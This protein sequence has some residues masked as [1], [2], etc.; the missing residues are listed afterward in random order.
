MLESF[1]N[2]CLRFHPVVDF[3]MRRALSDDVIEGHRVLKGT[4]IILNTGRMHH[5]EF[6]L[7]PDD[8]SLENFGRTVSRRESWFQVSGPSCC[9]TS[10]P[11]FWRR[12]VKDTLLLIVRHRLNAGRVEKCMCS[13]TVHTP[14]A[15]L[16]LTSR[17]PAVSSSSSGSSPLL[18]AVRIG[19]SRLRGEARGHGHDEIRPGDAPLPLLGLLPLWPDAGLPPTDQQPQPA[20]CRTSA[21]SPTSG[22][23]LPAAT[24]RP[25]ANTLSLNS[26]CTSFSLQVVQS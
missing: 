10:C 11:E 18:P 21:G 4:N 14:H 23:E 22:H 9:F 25:L 3:T 24:A 12:A 2:E 26:F 13:L 5:N 8:F 17:P 16:L 19:P 20:A 1:I 7:K 6:F 15:E